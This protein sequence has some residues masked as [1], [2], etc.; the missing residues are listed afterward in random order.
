MNEALK[1]SRDARCID[2]DERCF[3]LF[4]IKPDRFIR[5][6]VAIRNDLFVFSGY[7]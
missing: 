5:I 4:L 2:F 7:L 6:L 3:E 1:I